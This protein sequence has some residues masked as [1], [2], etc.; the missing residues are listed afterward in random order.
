M[1]KW[2]KLPGEINFLA[3]G[4]CDEKTLFFTLAAMVI[5]GRLSAGLAIA[6]EQ[7]NSA[8]LPAQEQAGQVPVGNRSI[9]CG[10]IEGPPG[11]LLKDKDTPEMVFDVYVRLLPDI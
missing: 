6:W 5:A 1:E 4:G 10:N 2:A 9:S 8:Q 3:Y 7:R 11:G